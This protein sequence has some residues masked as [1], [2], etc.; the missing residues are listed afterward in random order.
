MD[1]SY[2]LLH[3]LADPDSS[4]LISDGG[5]DRKISFFFI[6]KNLF[7]HC[8]FVGFFFYYYY[9]VREPSLLGRFLVDF[10]LISFV[11]G[12]NLRYTQPAS[13]EQKVIIPLLE[14]IKQ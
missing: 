7:L 12:W 6:F 2:H 14:E 10:F 11:C 1:I 8:F 5:R 13:K 3:I 9:T 4:T